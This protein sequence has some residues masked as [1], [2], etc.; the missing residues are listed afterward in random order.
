MVR[1]ARQVISRCGL[2][3]DGRTTE[4]GRLSAAADTNEAWPTRC[5]VSAPSAS[6]RADEG[7]RLYG[8]RR[9]ADAEAAYRE[10]IRLDP[11]LSAAHAGL[12]AALGRRASSTTRRPP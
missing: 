2:A 6:T 7:D 8:Q 11:Y 4:L 10:A 9:Y 12:G 5:A 3:H 1:N